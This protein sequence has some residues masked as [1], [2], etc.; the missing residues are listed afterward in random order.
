[1][2]FSRK[3]TRF[4]RLLIVLVAVVI[5][6]FVLRIGHAGSLTPAS[7]PGSTMYD[8]SDVYDPIASGSYNSSAIT[9]DRNG[10]ALE[11]VKCIINKQHGSAC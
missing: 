5:T 4:L 2:I 1:M 8:L 9:A 11:I 7:A 3:L 10:S 6:S